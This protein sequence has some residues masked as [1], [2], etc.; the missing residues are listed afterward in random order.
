MQVSVEALT[1]LGRKI[2]VSVPAEK[3]QNEI[4]TRLREL[5]Q[6]IKM[7]GFRPGKV[8]ETVIRSRYA[9]SIRFEV[10]REMVQK[11]LPEALKQCELTPAG[12]P[13]I[14][15][16]QIEQ[17]K[18]FIYTAQFD[19]Y[20]EI[21]IKGITDGEIELIK[22]EVND[23]DLDNLIE[24]LRSQNQTWEK[25]ER[26]VKDGDKVRMDFDGKVDE[27]PFDGGKAENYELI[28]GSQMMIPGFEAGIIGHELNKPFDLAVTFPADYGH[29]A[30][31]GKDAIFTIILHEIEEGKLP[32]LDENFALQFDIK[33]GGIEAFKKDIRESMERELEN[34]VDSLNRE[35]IFSKLLENNPFELP[36]SLVENEIEQLN[37]EMYHRVYGKEHHDD[38]KVPTFPRE[39]FE[40]RA[41]RHVHLGLLLA[42][43]IKQN[44]MVVDKQRV[45]AKIDKM[46]T[47]Y[48]DSDSMRNFY[49][50]DK[51]RRAEVEALVMEEM[52]ADKII[53]NVQ[54]V[55]KTMTYD[56]IMNPKQPTE[57]KGA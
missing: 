11:T 47:A 52:V 13:S 17:G 30:L 24:K 48:Q 16:E 21:E 53:E 26:P 19:I 33:E 51:Q 50:K 49:N 4:N 38:E 7:P 57:E 14:E 3:V 1:G 39:L 43:Y 9:D 54:K 42:E 8:P 28:I 37:H 34:R 5:K 44:E 6:K 12:Y 18:D 29:K 36:S 25:V 46:I 56:E 27:K 45:D 22:A 35:R 55:E 15:P 40:S 23:S 41:K 10:S 31:A 20:P 32:E 2:R